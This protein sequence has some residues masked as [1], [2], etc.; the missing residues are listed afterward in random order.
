MPY[1][2]PQAHKPRQVGVVGISGGPQGWVGIVTKHSAHSKLVHGKWVRWT[3]HTRG[4][5]LPQLFT[6]CVFCK[7]VE[8]GE[9]CGSIVRRQAS[10]G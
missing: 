10:A 9:H 2:I 8:F 7:S 5:Q 1:R 3:Q 6:V 4:K